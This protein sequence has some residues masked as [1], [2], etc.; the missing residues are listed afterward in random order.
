MHCLF[1]FLD[2]HSVPYGAE[3]ARSDDDR[4]EVA[5]EQATER[6]EPAAAASSSDESSSWSGTTSSYSSFGWVCV[7]FKSLEAGFDICDSSID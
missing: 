4:I 2:A 3:L 1:S 5:S 7:L 6:V